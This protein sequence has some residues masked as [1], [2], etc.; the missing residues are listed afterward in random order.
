M[1]NAENGTGVR[2]WVE[3]EGKKVY[4]WDEDAKH[5]CEKEGLIRN[6][7]EYRGTYRHYLEQLL[8]RMKERRGSRV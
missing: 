4:A 2:S 5:E 6:G 8:S 1:R 7:E 3:S